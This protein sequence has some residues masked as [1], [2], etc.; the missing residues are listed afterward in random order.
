MKTTARI[1]LAL[2]AIAILSVIYTSK[3]EFVQFIGHLILL[4]AFPWFI[5]ALL[6]LAFPRTP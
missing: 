6:I 3:D 2:I 5:I 1:L 4:C